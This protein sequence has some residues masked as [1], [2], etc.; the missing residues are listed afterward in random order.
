MIFIVI[1]QILRT[2]CQLEENIPSLNAINDILSSTSDP[3]DAFREAIKPLENAPVFNDEISVIGNFDREPQSPT[4]SPPRF[5]PTNQFN[6]RNSLT[7]NIF[8]PPSRDR[9]FS[10]LN[11]DEFGNPL[12]DVLNTDTTRYELGAGANPERLRCPR[13]WVEFKG[14]CYKFNRSPPKEVVEAREICQSYR[15]DDTDRADLVSISNFEEHWFLSETLNRIDP[16]HRRWYISARQDN[17]NQWINAG[18]NTPM[19]NLQDYFLDPN[20]FGELQDGYKKDYLTYSFSLLNRRWGFQPVYGHEKYLYICEV[21]I[22]EV[23]YLINDDRTAAYGQPLGDPR[24]IPMGPFFVRQPNHTVFDLSRRNIVNDVSLLCIAQGWPTPSY[25]WFKEIY[26]NDLLEDVRVDPLEDTRLT[27]SGGQLIINSPDQTKDK[28]T[29]FCTASNQF[30]K[31]RSKSVSLSFGFIGEFILR[32]SDEQGNENWGKAVKCDAPHYYPNVRFYWARDYFPNFVEEDRRIMVSQDGYIYF[33]ALENID[34]GNYS[35]NVQ[36]T[37]SSQGR[38]GP[39]FSID[40]QPHPNHQQLRFPQNFPKSFPE[41]PIAG[42]E[43]RLECIAFGYPVPH[44]NWTRVGANL[45]RGSYITNYNRV[46]II[47]RVRVEDQ[48]EYECHAK[49]DKIHISA[50]LMLSIQSKPVFT[51]PIGDQ[52]VDEN[53]EVVWTCEAFGIPYVEYSWLRNGRPLTKDAPEDRDRY[54]IKDNILKIKQVDK[55]R[56]EGMYQCKATNDLDSRFSSGQ[57]KVLRLRPS[58]TKHPLEP[59]LYGAENGNITLQCKP[60]AAPRP[61]ITWYHLGNRIGSGGKRIIYPSGSLLISQLTAAEAGQYECV[62][63]NKHGTD[64]NRTILA[65]K[66]GPSFKGPEATRPNPRIIATKGETVQLRCAA[67][68]DDVLDRAYYWRLNDFILQFY[69]DY[70]EERLLELKNAGGSRV[71]SEL[72][73]HI[74]FK[75][76]NNAEDIFNNALYDTENL[77][78]KGTGDLQK[79]RRGIRD[80][81]LIIDNITIAEAGQYECAVETSVGTIFATSEVIVHSPPGPPGGVTSVNMGNVSCTVAWTDGAFYGRRIDTYRIEGR[82]DHND[83]WRVLADNVPGQE[84]DYQGKRAKI[85]GRRQY[86]IENMLT[87]WSAYSFRVAAYNGLGIGEWSEPSPSYNTRPGRPTKSVTNIRTGEGGRTGDLIVSWDPLSRED[88]NAP[89]I[90]YKLFYKQ[91]EDLSFK[92]V[93]SLRHLGNIDTYTIRIDKEY[94]WTPYIVKIQVFN[95]KCLDTAGCP[96]PM[97][98]EVEVMSAEDL[99]QVAPTKVGARPFNSTAI[100][101]QW[102][103]IP[104]VR[105]KVRQIISFFLFSDLNSINFFQVRGKLIGHRIKYWM[106]KDN[107]YNS[108]LE[109]KESQYVLSRSTKSEALIIGLL[110]NE[111][112]YVRVMAY[113]SAGN[114]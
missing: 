105:E 45:P 51:I 27:I 106:K 83:T 48:G 43:V 71:T 12:G 70:E 35:C 8:E 64:R 63:T 61:N 62:A 100:R 7:P 113:N 59:R 41:A 99:P 24:Y 34:R 50:K 69:D 53:D 82:T 108:T 33:S 55:D 67:E 65:V 39:F 31:I 84:I 30:G 87:P 4:P 79:F 102:Q 26:K 40:V 28:G 2:N 11:V 14:S 17:Q 101:V 44:Y 19:L 95:D 89:G 52:F 109:V 56:D 42:E 81:Y 90:Y 80:G 25:E 5:P 3:R 110:P 91:R 72:E 6:D 60:E 88:Q 97:S 85:D 58:F 76:L 77:R 29:Y 15:H 111:Y 22:E 46:L 93:K 104:N 47:P 1:F 57:L 9:D 75:P 92:Q 37:I 107:E 49:N 114:Q 66:K 86:R 36:S 20:E 32:R 18:D 103:P 96:G 78:Y 68:A 21:P 98:E 13:N 38:N 10:R 54:I 16:E 23:N 73:H 94:Y 112:Y 74:S